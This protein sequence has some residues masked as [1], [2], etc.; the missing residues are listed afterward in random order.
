MQRI[1]LADWKDRNKTFAGLTGHNCQWEPAL[2]LALWEAQQCDF[3]GAKRLSCCEHKRWQVGQYVEGSLASPV[4]RMHAY[5]LGVSVLKA[6]TRWACE[7][8][9]VPF[10]L[11]WFCIVPRH[12]LRVKQLTPNKQIWYI[13]KDFLYFAKKKK[14]NTTLQVLHKT[15]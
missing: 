15:E 7:G 4:G 6:H 8:C 10:L 13:N 2:S 12:N 3:V 11:L 5:K 14:Q 1:L 9:H